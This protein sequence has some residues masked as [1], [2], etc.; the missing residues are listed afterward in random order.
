MVKINCCNS[1]VASV[2]ADGM[3]CVTKTQHLRGDTLSASALVLQGPLETNPVTCLEFSAIKPEILATGD[4]NGMVT[5]WETKMGAKQCSI[6]GHQGPCSGLAFSQVNAK[7]LSSCG[8]DGQVVLYDVVSHQRIKTTA[9]KI[10][11]NIEALVAIA[12]A[13]DGV[14]IAAATASGMIVLIDLKG[15]SNSKLTISEGDG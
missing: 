13:Q 10:E 3:I 14:T 5:I 12:A 4:L 2:S 9:G 7:L 1:S 8:L 15:K 11:E 6:A